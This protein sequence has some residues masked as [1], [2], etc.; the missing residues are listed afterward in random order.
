M[1]IFDYPHP[2]SN[3]IGLEQID[4]LGDIFRWT[5]LTGMNRG[6]QSSLAGLAENWFE[7]GSGKVR[8]IPG[9]VKSNDTRVNP[10]SSILS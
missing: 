4:R 6:F 8:F 10:A 5:P 2:M 9:Q 3:A 7:G 1:W